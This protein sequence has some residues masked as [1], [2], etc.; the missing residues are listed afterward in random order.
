VI[1]SSTFS[2]LQQLAWEEAR[3]NT[4]VPPRFKAIFGDQSSNNLLAVSMHV[5]VKILCC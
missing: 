2:E 3:A 4:L 5:Y 1:V